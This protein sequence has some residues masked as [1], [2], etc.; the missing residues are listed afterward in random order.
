MTAYEAS[1][2]ACKRCAYSKQV[3]ALFNTFE[4]R[5]HSPTVSRVPVQY[6]VRQWVPI[7]PVMRGDD[8]CFDFLSNGK[9]EQQP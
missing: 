7:W 1:R 8:M 9:L 4:C 6:D 3:D 2:G 5:R